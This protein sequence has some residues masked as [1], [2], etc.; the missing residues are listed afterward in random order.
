MISGSKARSR[1][2]FSVFMYALFK[3]LRPIF[4]LCSSVGAIAPWSGL[5]LLIIPGVFRVA[6]SKILRHSLIPIFTCNIRL[7]AGVNRREKKIGTS[8]K[9]VYSGVGLTRRT[10]VCVKRSSIFL[11]DGLRHQQAGTPCAPSSQRLCN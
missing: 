6:G 8:V 2:T 9:G 3:Y 10:R 7:T 4:H 1:W 11:V 5:G